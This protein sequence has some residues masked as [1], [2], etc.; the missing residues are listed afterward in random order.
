MIII[1]IVT[2]RLLMNIFEKKN[3]TDTRWES[4]HGKMIDGWATG[5]NKTEK[6]THKTN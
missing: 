2:I 6:K 4:T 3:G 1:I 5:R